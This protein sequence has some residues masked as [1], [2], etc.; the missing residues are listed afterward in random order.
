MKQYKLAEKIIDNNDIVK[1]ANWLLTMPRLTMGKLT[2]EFEKQ[3]AAWVGTKYA[4]FCNSGSS[5]NLLLAYAA[6]LSG[7][8]RNKKIIVPSVGWVTTI[9][10][11]IQ[12]GFE[13]VMC[14]AD[15]DD[16]GLDLDHLEKLLKEHVP[17]AVMMVQV[18]GVP[19]KMRRLKSLQDQYGFLLFEDAC[20]ALGAEYDG[21]KVGSFSTM[22]TF[23]FYFGHQLST[24]EGGMVNTDDKHFYDLLL[25]LRSHGWGKDL[26]HETEE[27]LMAKYVVDEFHKPF[28]FF[29]PGFN[30]RATDINAFLGLEM[31]KKADEVVR[32]RKANHLT[33]AQNLKTVTFQRWTAPAEPCSI[34]F[35]ALA[36]DV[37]HRVK[38]V[39]AL[40]ANRIETRLFSAGNLG[41]HPFWFERYGKFHNEISDA[42]HS[43]GFFLPNNESITKEDVIF[44]C[45]VVNKA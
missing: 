27:A 32:I 45:N 19:G 39:R 7:K 35:G 4:V 10:P 1:L 12:F 34:S 15:K 9:A 17:G 40:D 38:I 30:L 29:V 16:F 20:A 31:I 23:S 24:I 26:D 5:A 11:F 21:R 3:W 6:L 42:V 13:P 43:R 18:L 2:P 14:A 36:R 8:L 25:M 37:E 33:Y 41:L 28:T 44:I 22:S